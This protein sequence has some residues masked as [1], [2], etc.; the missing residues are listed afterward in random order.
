MPEATNNIP[1]ISVGM[2]STSWRGE[3]GGE[4]CLTG[5]SKE[6]VD[7]LVGLALGTYYVSV[8]KGRLKVHPVHE[9]LPDPK[10]D[11]KMGPFW[12]R[13]SDRDIAEAKLEVVDVKA[14]E[15]LQ[16]HFPTFILHGVGAGGYRWGSNYMKEA[17]RLEGWGFLC[18]RS[19]R[20]TDGKY[21]E[22][23]YLSSI[24]MAEGELAEAIAKVKGQGVEAEVDAVINFM[25]RSASF[26]S[27]DVTVQRAA[28]CID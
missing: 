14:G 19:R 9:P 4:V 12:Q 5:L 27:F 3:N 28:L 24:F 21:S 16:G 17:T 22:L 18:L 13:A 1:E 6:E 8:E 25:C 10:V 2:R 11:P 23:W 26:G 7:Q 20:S 15:G